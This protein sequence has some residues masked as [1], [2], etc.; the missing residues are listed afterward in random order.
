MW[1]LVATVANSLIGLIAAWKYVYFF[2]IDVTKFGLISLQSK[3]GNVPQISPEVA[4]SSSRTG[5]GIWNL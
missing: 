4:E 2:P 1:C 5:A 3:L